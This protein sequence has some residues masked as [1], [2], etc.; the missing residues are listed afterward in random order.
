MECATWL[1]R[2]ALLASQGSSREVIHGPTAPPRAFYDSHLP[3]ASSSRE[4]VGMPTTSFWV[5]HSVRRTVRVPARRSKQTSICKRRGVSVEVSHGVSLDVAEAL[6]PWV[7]RDSF[8]PASIW[9]SASLSREG[10]L[11]TGSGVAYASG[12]VVLRH[13]FAA[14]AQPLTAESTLHRLLLP[15]PVITAGRLFQRARLR[16]NHGANSAY[17][18][19]WPS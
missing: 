19:R 2:D 9:I 18:S 11:L 17:L 10:I 5:R 12:H 3:Q 15:P 1:R 13:C 14:S 16:N 4:S 7:A 8:L 6:R